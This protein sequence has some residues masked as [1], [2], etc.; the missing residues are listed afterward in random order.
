MM[1]CAHMPS[2]ATASPQRP[3]AD[4][5]PPPHVEAQEARYIG[6]CWMEADGTIRLFL[7]AETKAACGTIVGHVLQDYRPGDRQYEEILK[8]VGPMRPGERRP[9]PAWPD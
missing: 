8:H 2:E 9:V 3:I 1:C 6:E 4:A 5:V 7:R